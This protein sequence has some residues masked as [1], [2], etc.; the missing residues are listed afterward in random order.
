MMREAI[1]ERGGNG[2]FYLVPIVPTCVKSHLHRQTK[3]E[4]THECGNIAVPLVPIVPAMACVKFMAE[5]A[6][7]Q[8]SGKFPVG[9]EQAFLIAAGE[10]KV[11]HFLR[12]NRP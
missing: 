11:W 3:H 6:L 12:I 10:K 9:R 5:V 1:H 8:K 7:V 2:Y 4:A